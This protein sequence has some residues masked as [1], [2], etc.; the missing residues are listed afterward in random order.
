MRAHRLR[1]L[2]TASVIAVVLL[3]AVAV[4]YV[5]VRAVQA[6]EHLAAA[7]DAAAQASALLAG[8][9]VDG[10]ET[11]IAAM[12][13]HAARVD[14]GADP[15]WRLAE[16]V[17]GA[18]ANLAAVRIVSDGL[19][20]LGG[21]TAVPL[22]SVARE[23][24]GVDSARANEVLAAS[25]DDLAG[26]DDAVGAV[27]DELAG[28]DRS[29]LIPEVSGGV[30]TLDRVLAEAGPLTKG[31]AEAAALLPPLLGIDEPRTVLVAVQNTAELRTGG[32][33]TGTFIQLDA[34]GGRV[35][36]TGIRDSSSFAPV[37]EP[38][39][40]LRA[41]EQRSFGD[42]IG[43][44]VQDA[45]MTADFTLTARLAS[46]WWESATGVVP[47]AVVSVDP[48]VMAAVLRV[49]G[50]VDSIAGTLTADDIVDRLLVTPYLSSTPEEQSDQ[51]ADAAT[52]VFTALVERAD[53]LGLVESLR[54]PLAEGRVSLWSARPAEQEIIS[55]SALAGPLARQEQAGD[56]AF[57]V[58]FNDATGGKL[59]PYLS[60][61]LGVATTTCR[62]DGRE[63]VSITVDLGSALP[64]DA[65]TAFPVSVTGGGLFGAAVGDIAPTV[66]VVTP[67][68]WLP[69]GVSLDGDLVASVAVEDGERL[70]VTRRTDL[71]PGRSRT[72]VFRFIAPD[73]GDV[74]PVLIH[75]PLLTEP[76][77][78]RVAAAEPCASS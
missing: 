27:R 22:L 3:A 39:L 37:A 45:S 63:D 12:T 31:A 65:A 74:E 64:T 41:G 6:R 26:A 19:A 54:A 34:E 43:R 69:G 56:D 68:G 11:A 76:G 23:L 16:T 28:L 18:G 72:L 71:A 46:T 44:F 57:A 2:I 67:P 30:D 48:L 60:V 24:R 13:D 58:Y 1:R 32:G 29:A 75:T 7:A 20:R 4:L 5:G 42:G 53:V 25:A 49:T 70:A 14:V 55:R 9:D 52:A 50:P 15:V 40:P 36:V 38:L 17:P 21:D 73:G 78:A 35:A 10:A 8:G 61:G 47:D 51:F 33:I 77:A 62:P 66:T 59:T